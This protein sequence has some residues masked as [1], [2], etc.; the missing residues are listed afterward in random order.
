MQLSSSFFCTMCVKSEIFGANRKLNK[1]V[2]Y[3][4]PSP[5]K[6]RNWIDRTSQH[7]APMIRSTQCARK[8]K[9]FGSNQLKRWTR[10]ATAVQK[11]P[12]AMLVWGTQV[13]SPCRR[14]INMV[15]ANIGKIRPQSV[16]FECFLDNCYERKWKIFNF[17]WHSLITGPKIF[18]T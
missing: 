17:T 3:C 6:C 10:N 5:Q 11:R 14:D 18:T 4:W 7:P 16:S 15:S 12:N 13:S 2:I 8:K 9:R 1:Y